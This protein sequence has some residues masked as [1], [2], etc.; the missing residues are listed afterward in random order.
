MNRHRVLRG[1]AILSVLGLLGWGAGDALGSAFTVTPVRVFLGR[2]A[3]SALLNVKNDST[4]PI[5][6]QI[7]LKAWNQGPDGD[8]QLTDTTDL[9]F[10]PT[11]MEL[12]AGEEKK[13]RV[14]SAFKAPV[15]TERSYRIFFEEL[16][17]PQVTA[18]LEQKQTAAQVRVLTKMGV[19]IFIQPANLVIKADLTSLAVD[20]KKV[21]F[22]VRNI[23]S[24]FFTVT[25]A[26]LTGLTKSGT[27]TF[28]REQ[29][30]WYVL[31]GGVRRFQFEVP[32]EFCATTDHIRVEIGSSLTDDKGTPIPIFQ[33]SPFN[34]CK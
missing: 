32:V 15:A 13:V 34:G 10:F 26:M 9:V 5:R 1:F 4:E 2:G 14:G 16:P 11:I 31:A 21:S 23:G 25:K 12:S 8:M 18:T 7:S 28:T 17:P 30:G 22:E 19:P 6:F 24:T 20:G 33:E 29:D 3:S 27:P